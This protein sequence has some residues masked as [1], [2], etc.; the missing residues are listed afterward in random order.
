MITITDAQVLE[1]VRD[2][3]TK[4][5]A[6]LRP[7]IRSEL[8]E[9]MKFVTEEEG[10]AILSIGGKQPVRA[11]RRAM[12]DHG[13]HRMKLAG[14][15]LYKRVGENSVVAAVAKLT[16]KPAPRKKGESGSQENRKDLKL[17]A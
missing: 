8:V 11:F 16:V 5:V 7:M 2:Q 13:V 17:V 15:W 9:E 6:E 10:I 14:R 12:N 1:L 4:V 3:V